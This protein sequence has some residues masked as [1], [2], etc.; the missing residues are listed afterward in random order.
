M[1]YD[2]KNMEY[3]GN[4]NKTKISTLENSKIEYRHYSLKQNEDKM[5]KTM[6]G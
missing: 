2:N 3:T 1:V 4:S 5:S 6:P